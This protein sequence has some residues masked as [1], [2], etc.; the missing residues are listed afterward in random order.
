VFRGSLKDARIEALLRNTKDKLP[1]NKR[2][3]MEA[4]WTLVKEADITVERTSDAAGASERQ[5]YYMRKVWK[6]LLHE[7]PEERRKLLKRNVRQ[8]TWNQ[9]RRLFDDVDLDAD[10][11]DWKEVETQK[12]V[13]ALLRAKIGQGL[14]KHPDITAKALE[15]LNG[16]LPGALVQHWFGPTELREI[17]DGMQE[18]EL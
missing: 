9:A 11:E 6:W 15:R 13:D 7:L 10:I 12:L 5:I 16:A 14:S 8:V 1:M 2:D 18:Y 3:K 17:A 4:A